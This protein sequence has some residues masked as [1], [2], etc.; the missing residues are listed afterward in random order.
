MSQFN[1][2]AFSKIFLAME[3]LRIL[4]PHVKEIFSRISEVFSLHFKIFGLFRFCEC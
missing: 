3:V 2:E 4:L 1:N